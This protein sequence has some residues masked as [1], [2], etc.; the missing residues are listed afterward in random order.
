MKIAL[1]LTTLLLFLTSPKTLFAEEKIKPTVRNFSYLLYKHLEI[2]FPLI[3]SIERISTF[4]ESDDE[5]LYQCIDNAKKNLKKGG[6]FSDGLKKCPYYFSR[7]MVKMI[8]D[9]EK[10]GEL[11][12]IFR[13]FSDGIADGEFKRDD[14]CENLPLEN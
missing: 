2:A 12:F 14:F 11:G 6:L 9:G 4:Y 1:M 5:E 7:K 3:Y 13:D 8:K 10:N